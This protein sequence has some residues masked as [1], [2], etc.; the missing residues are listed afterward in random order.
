MLLKFLFFSQLHPENSV[1]HKITSELFFPDL[2][3]VTGFGLDWMTHNFYFTDSWKKTVTVCSNGNLSYSYDGS[4][5]SRPYR[6]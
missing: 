2:K 1:E 5:S 3:N 6:Y 4:G